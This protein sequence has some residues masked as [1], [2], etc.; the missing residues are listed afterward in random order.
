GGAQGLE[1]IAEARDDDWRTMWEVNVLGLMRMTRALLPALLASG[2]GHV[3]N[4]GSL[5]RLATHARRAGYTSVKLAV[6]AISGTLRL[7]LLGKPV[8]VTEIDPGMGET[9][10][11][12]VRF[13]GD[14]EKASAV[15]RGMQP[16]TAEDVAD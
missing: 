12:Q 9:E 2:D 13:R 1:P 16:L 6:R 5:G 8:R 15:Y 11:S 14:Q 10:F 3:V 4:L 7:E